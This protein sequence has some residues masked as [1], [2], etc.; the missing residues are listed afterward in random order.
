M[1]YSGRIYLYLIDP[2]FCEESEKVL[3]HV[4]ILTDFFLLYFTSFFCVPNVLQICYFIEPGILQPLA[5]LFLV[6]LRPGP[7]PLRVKR[8][9]TAD[10]VI[11]AGQ[12]VP[13]GLFDV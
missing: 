10:R 7:R 8:V 6:H 4:E 13:K 9:L 3:D 1:K 5:L 11:H 2:V 12:T